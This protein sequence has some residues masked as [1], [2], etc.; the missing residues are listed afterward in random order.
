M[1]ID[2]VRCASLYVWSWIVSLVACR[3]RLRYH[4]CVI[5]IIDKII[6][7]NNDKIGW[8]RGND[9]Y[10]KGGIKIGYYIEND[11][12]DHRGSKIAYLDGS[13]I[14]MEN[15]RSPISLTDN[16]KKIEGS[17]YSDL[18]KA[19]VLVLLGDERY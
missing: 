7:R 1:P 5:K 15:G 8:L 6:Y 3:G 16:N 19:A 17:G 4:K 18:C 11:I 9:I 14:R 10:N 2:A 13:Y 12:Y